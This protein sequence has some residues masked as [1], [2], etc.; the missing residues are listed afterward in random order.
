[1]QHAQAVHGVARGRFHRL[2][3]AVRYQIQP[4]IDRP[5]HLGLAAHQRLRH[6]V[7]PAGELA[8]RPQHFAQAFLQLVGANRLR[9]RQFRAP[10]A[11]AGDDDGDHQQQHQSQHAEPDQRLANVNRQVA[12]N[13]KNFVHAAM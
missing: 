12:D 7:D 1:M 13:E 4:L 6:G 9:H 8:L 3:D 10:A 5:R 2:A 11:R